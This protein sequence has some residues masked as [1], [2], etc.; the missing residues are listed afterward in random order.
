MKTMKNVKTPKSV[1][2]REA[3]RAVDAAQTAASE[4]KASLVAREQTLR[5]REVRLAQA[6]KAPVDGPAL[7]C[8]RP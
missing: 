8:A 4:E 2:V 3:A 5:E 6:L 7:P 1:Q